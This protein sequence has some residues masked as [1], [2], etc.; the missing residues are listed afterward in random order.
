MEKETNV[1]VYEKEAVTIYAYWK[2]F[3]GDIQK[4]KNSIYEMFRWDMTYGYAHDILVYESNAMGAYVRLIIK[5]AFEDSVV[6]TMDRL[7]FKELRIGHDKIGAVECTD[8]PDDALYD[9][10]VIDY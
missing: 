3:D 7:G 10:I 4:W 1:T 6:E 8:L 2:D 9:I 5:T